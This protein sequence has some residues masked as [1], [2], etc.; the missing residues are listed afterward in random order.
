[1]KNILI[2]FLLPLILL[3]CQGSSSRKPETNTPDNST[4]IVTKG[5]NS[6]VAVTS[7]QREI[8][9]GNES[10]SHI[11]YYRKYPV[12]KGWIAKEKIYISR[13]TGKLEVFRELPEGLTPS[14]INDSLIILLEEESI[15]LLFFNGRKDTLEVGTQVIRAI[16]NPT[17]SKVLISPRKGKLVLL[18][19]GDGS[20]KSMGFNAGYSF[21][22]V[23]DTLYY[24]WGEGVSRV[25]INLP[26]ESIEVANQVWG[27]NSM[28]ITPNQKFLM[29]DALHPTDG[30]RPAIV[31]VETGATQFP[32][33]YR[34]AE[35]Y[36]SYQENAVVFYHPNTFEVWVV[37][38]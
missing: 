4:T 9:G 21:Q 35:H 11:G 29:C 5:L 3:G 31:E 17:A 23:G 13:E 33:V 8:Q 32:D 20:R 7:D 25:N 1:M 37:K 27:E 10:Y 28:I 30:L 18:D 38:P 36:Y 19:L 12:F 2:T 34:H 6:E 26:G 22:L 24:F 16:A 15:H 14:F